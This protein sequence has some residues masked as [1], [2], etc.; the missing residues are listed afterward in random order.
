MNQNDV[1]NRI[2]EKGS[3]ALESLINFTEKQKIA[4]ISIVA[5]LAWADNKID[6]QEKLL[7]EDIGMRAGF[8]KSKQIDELLK[9]T[10]E[11]DSSKYQ[12]WVDEIKNS[13]IKYILI[14]D[15]YL[16]AFVDGIC[17]ES[18]TIYIKYIAAKLEINDNQ[19]D[20]IKE[21]AE[22]TRLAGNPDLK[23]IYYEE[24]MTHTY[25]PEDQKRLNDIKNFVSRVISLSV[26]LSLINLNI[27]M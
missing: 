16:T 20:L 27:I 24:G 22:Q 9:Q 3:E 26:P 8:S 19:R 5:S 25:S 6:E 21:F 2:L 12:L 15:M 7:L 11:F 14:A 18:E 10:R 4:Y 13:P 17:K 1:L 23:P